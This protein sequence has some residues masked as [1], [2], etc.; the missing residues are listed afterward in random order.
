MQVLFVHLSDIHIKGVDDPILDRKE[1]I[2]QA[3]QNT[4]LGVDY[5]FLIITGDI[6]FSGKEPEYNCAFEFVSS[7][8]DSIR[9]YSGKDVFCVVVPG[10]HDCDCDSDKPVVR[11]TII[12]DV[13]KNAK[14]TPDLIDVC[15][16]AQDNY[17]LFSEVFH[18]S[19]TNVLHSEKLLTVLQYA[20][21]ECNIIFNC[22]NTSWISQRVEEP[23]K[24]Y[25]PV[26]RCAGKSIQT[27]ADIV[28]SLMHHT[29]N[30]FKP[31]NA[32]EL[33]NHLE[34]TS[35][36]VITGHEHVSSK[37]LKNNLQGNFTEYIAGDIL[38]H[39]EDAE[40]SGFNIVLLDIGNKRQKICCYG[41][42]GSCYCPV[43]SDD[44]WIPYK[45]SQKSNRKLLQINPAFDDFLDDPG[46]A[47]KHPRKPELFLH[48]IFVFPN[49]RDLQ[50]TEQ[51]GKLLFQDIKD[52]SALC[53]LGKEKNRI[54]L[55]GAERSG[56]TALCRTLYKRYYSESYVPIYL[57]GH[58]I[59][60]SS[61]EK[62]MSLIEKSFCEQY[63]PNALETYKQLE[64]A[65]KV[66][67]IDD[68]NRT[69][70]N[71]KHRA[72]LLKNLGQYYDSIVVTANS[73][74]QI[75]EIVY[76]EE[77]GKIALEDYEKYEIMQFGNVLRSMLIDKW[78]T[79]GQEEYIEEGELI[80]KSDDAKKVIDIVIGRNYVPAY[81]IFMLTILQSF[82]AVVPHDLTE[83]SYGYYYDFLIYQA[84]GRIDGK[85]EEID[86]YVN[87]LAELANYFFHEK[88]REISWEKLVDFHKW[89][90]DEYAVTSSIDKHI[91]NLIK[92]S[93]LTK[94][95]DMISFKYRYIYYYFVA[96]YISRNITS[97]EMVTIIKDMCKRLYQEEFAN[98][99][100]FLTH[101]SKDPII[102]DEVLANAKSIFSGYEPIRFERDIDSINKLTNEVPRL[103]LK[104]RPVREVRKE[105]LRKKDELEMLRGDDTFESA[106]FDLEEEVE[107]LDSISTLNLAFKTIEIVGQILN[108]YYGSLK[109]GKKLALCEQAYFLGLRATRVCFSM[110]GENTEHLVAAIE[111]IVKEKEF[112]NEDK[113]KDFSR[114]LLFTLFYMISYSLLK[115]I[116]QYIGS[117]RISETLRE[118][119]DRNDI[120]SVHLTDI[121]IRL[122]YFKA[123]P[124]E[125]MKKLE[126]RLS[127]NVLPLTVLKRMVIDHLYMF[128]VSYTEKQRICNILGIPMAS[129]RMIEMSSD[130][131]K[132]K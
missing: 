45:T 90:C 41:W 77:D 1:K 71:F 27:N 113:I 85:N 58:R 12:R 109:R 94:R 35:H 101:H 128:P 130:Q 99:I 122:D 108:N 28:I 13:Q 18:E 38:Q 51:D 79:I 126:K 10:N 102:L 73:L 50:L 54:L 55:I 15:C 65:K 31:E 116:S 68:F 9:D 63:S 124:Y 114:K 120:N 75:E 74:F 60:S 97:N 61:I 104:D 107:D 46:A 29:F 25:Y 84:L 57:E 17:F 106:E 32:R 21:S 20:L 5:V 39:D 37:S 78:N 105:V 44:T 131:K 92:A 121:S 6:A 48:D 119:K 43:E 95:S 40:K 26:A 2:V 132:R 89:Y 52:S 82:E 11:E 88:S 3:F 86:A 127:G 59:K 111:S 69:K 76:E 129:Q 14:V 66:L 30:W 53:E 80:R 16:E 72:E 93:M 103:V 91:S 4:A 7:I 112:T 118:V 49:V 33:S 98:I 19:A 67:V 47:F 64:K 24:L 36:I 117:E 115:S 70:L 125:E 110:L 96:K 34:E 100:M 81:P 22:Y 123:F 42:D 23:G 83:S 56:K 87:Y 8:Q 62:C